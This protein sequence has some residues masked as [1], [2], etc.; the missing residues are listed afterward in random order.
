MKKFFVLLAIFA[1]AMGSVFAVSNG[2]WGGVA[3]EADYNDTAAAQLNVSIDLT[4]RSGTYVIG[5]SGEEVTE[6]NVESVTPL[7]ELELGLNT[8]GEY[9]G[10]AYAYWSI[11]T[12]ADENDIVI[13]ISIP[14]KLTSDSDTTGIDWKLTS[15]EKTVTVNSTQTE[16]KTITGT[17]AAASTIIGSVPLEITTT[18]FATLDAVS[19]GRTL[20]DELYSG[21]IKLQI[22]STT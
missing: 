14:E 8:K 3:V 13:G 10:T 18:N 4:D 12:N 15:G 16:L 5:F 20:A 7:E 11:K 19:S 1:I 9:S 22:K 6:S 2:Q 17:E 21:V